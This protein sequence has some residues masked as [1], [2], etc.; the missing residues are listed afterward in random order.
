MYIADLIVRCSN[1]IEALSKELYCTLGGNMT[2]TDD[3]GNPRDLY[4]DTDCL[5]FLE[6][7]WNL[8]KMEW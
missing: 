3:Q 8:S 1:E 5:D 4:F 6:Q 2:P 7:K